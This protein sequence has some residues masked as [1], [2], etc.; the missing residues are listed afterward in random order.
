MATIIPSDAA[1]PTR[2]IELELPKDIQGQL[3]VLQNLVGGMIEF[4]YFADGSALMVDE[5]GLLKGRHVNER[6]TALLFTKSAIRGIE[7]VATVMGVGS[8]IVGDAVFLSRTDMRRLD[9]AE[10]DAIKAE[11]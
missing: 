11:G 5:E 4:V 9:D 10:A 1:L 2:E 3:T 7:N 8:A 6:A